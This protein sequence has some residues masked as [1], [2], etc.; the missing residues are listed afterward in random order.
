M[1]LFNRYSVI[2][3]LGEGG[4]GTVLLVQ[5]QTLG[6]QVALKI[7]KQDTFSQENKKEQLRQEKKIHSRITKHCSS[8]SPQYHSHI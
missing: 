5:D 3:K 7:L 6:I 4:F 8:K 1:L 2:K